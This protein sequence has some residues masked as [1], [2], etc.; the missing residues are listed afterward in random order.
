MADMGID[1]LLAIIGSKR[2]ALGIAV[3]PARR[4]EDPPVSVERELAQTA[5]AIATRSLEA[6]LTRSTAEKM[7]STI[8]V[9]SAP[10]LRVVDLVHRGH[11]GYIPFSRKTQSGASLPMFS[12]A[13]SARSG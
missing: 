13:Y 8:R 12:V 6:R 2:D 3:P 9:P 1:E 10:E 11:D 5:N 7:P 4:D